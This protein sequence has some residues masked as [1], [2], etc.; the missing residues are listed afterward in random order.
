[1]CHEK[2]G[3]T[4]SL[5]LCYC[6][7][8]VI[9]NTKFHVNS[10]FTYYKYILYSCASTAW[11]YEEHRNT[12]NHSGNWLLWF[13]AVTNNISKERIEMMQFYKSKNKDINRR[14]KA[15]ETLIIVLGEGG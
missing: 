2:E 4:N 12:E 14:K 11:L 3:V 1:M 6:I 7:A 9:K 8:L 10:Y 5:T 13:F 15:R